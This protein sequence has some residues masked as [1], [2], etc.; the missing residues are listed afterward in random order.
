MRKLWIAICALSMIACKEEAKNYVTFSGKIIDKN[1]DS[2]VLRT[3][4]YSKTIK[5]NQDGTFSDTLKVDA[6]IYNFYDGGESSNLY[7]QNGY[8]LN[9]TL[10][11]KMFDETI[12]YSGIGDKTNN[13]L[14]KKALMEETLFPPSLF[15][16]E[17]ADFKKNITEI[18]KKRA[19]FLEQNKDIEPSLYT[20][21][22]EDVDGF[23]EKMLGYFVKNKEREVERAKQFASY[24]GQPSATFKDYEN[25]AGGTTS[26]ADLKGNYV[27]IDIWAT[28]CGPCLAE[29]PALKEAEKEYHGKKVSFVSISVDNGRGYKNRSFEASKEGWKKMITEK[30][31][32]GI[33]LFSDKN[34][35][36]DF[37]AAYKV[38][39]IPR[40]I[41]IDPNG[42]VVNADA[43][44]PSSPKF[45]KLFASLDL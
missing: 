14:A 37:I 21:E 24:I 13:Y 3:Q 23:E 19:E 42:V 45:N 31:M 44:R 11:T 41:L 43:P 7:L 10:D 28:W 40:F 27:Y 20:T 26:L 16:F 1:S 12:A 22:K 15:D 29:L 38:N 35:K 8:D 18:N 32:G 25:F 4:T 17:E 6:G 9:M 36:S 39:S 33:Q 2:I 30:E 34:W 5:V